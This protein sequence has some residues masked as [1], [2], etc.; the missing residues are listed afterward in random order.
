MSQAI[1]TPSRSSRGSR[2]AEDDL[3][4]LR[5][6]EED[7]ESI[8]PTSGPVDFHNPFPPAD[9]PRRRKPRSR[10]ESE[11][12]AAGS[13]RSRGTRE[14]PRELPEEELDVG[15]NDTASKPRSHIDPHPRSSDSLVKQSR[16]RG[17]RG[18]PRGLEEDDYDEEDEIQVHEKISRP[19]ARGSG[20]TRDS[21]DEW[22][23]VHAPS[24]EEAI[25]MSGGLDIVEVAPRG[26][27][28]SVS[29][30][31]SDESE[32]TGRGKRGNTSVSKSVS[33]D[34]RWTEITKELVV[35]E[36]IERMGY[37]HEEMRHSY[38]IFSYLEPVRFHHLTVLPG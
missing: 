33:K 22:S 21:T 4:S 27:S 1:L 38:Y 25:E 5:R 36:A 20:H 30:S 19:R 18:V 2:R 26:D 15:I 12:M 8:S 3:P 9:R 10:R 35:R 16:G 23:V 31:E 28:S 6:E 34:E 7:D 14:L 32:D 11:S 24:K 17:S 13:S 37:E 29:G